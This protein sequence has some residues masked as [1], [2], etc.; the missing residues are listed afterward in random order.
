ML[1]RKSFLPALLCG[2]LVFSCGHKNAEVY[3]DEA[4]GYIEIIPSSVKVQ[5]LSIEKYADM[6]RA[7]S[8]HEQA[9]QLLERC[10]SLRTPDKASYRTMTPH[11]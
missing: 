3:E 7:S 10:I 8:R 6:T 5:E 11:H 4:R 9:L 1:C 2:T